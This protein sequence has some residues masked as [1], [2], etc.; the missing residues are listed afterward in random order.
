MREG[1]LTQHPFCQQYAKAENFSCSL[2]GVAHSVHTSDSSCSAVFYIHFKT[3]FLKEKKFIASL[4]RYNIFLYTFFKFLN[5]FLTLFKI[6]QNENECRTLCP[7]SFLVAPSPIN[8]EFGTQEFPCIALPFKRI[9]LCPKSLNITSCQHFWELK[10]TNIFKNWFKFIC[11]PRSW[12][13]LENDCH[14]V[15]NLLW[16]IYK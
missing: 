16:N 1:L 3:L 10:L 4:T 13:L 5:F 14:C 2:P 8:C 7:L 9:C 11:E 12:M 15:P 6:F